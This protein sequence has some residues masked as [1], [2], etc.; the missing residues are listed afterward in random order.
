VP[1]P[2]LLYVAGEVVLAVPLLGWYKLLHKRPH[3]QLPLP[4][5]RLL[6]GGVVGVEVE[7][8]KMLPVKLCS[9]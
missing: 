4:P 5:L 6:V 3:L 2:L 7:V 9:Q 1:Q 8:M